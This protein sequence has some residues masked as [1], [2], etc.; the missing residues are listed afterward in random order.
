MRSPAPAVLAA[1]LVLGLQV[2]PGPA[3]DE[4]LGRAAAFGRVDSAPLVLVP[5]GTA[6]RSRPDPKSARLV[7]IEEEAELQI[8]D[9]RGDWV[10]TAYRDWTGWLAPLGEQETDVAIPPDLRA[11]GFIFDTR[12]SEQAARLSSALGLFSQANPDFTSVGPWPLHTDVHDVELL[13]LLDR[14]AKQVPTLYAERFGLTPAV[15]VDP[16]PIVL[17][18]AEDQYRAYADENTDLGQL[19]GGGHASSTMAAL[20][21]ADGA[22]AAD[23][24]SIL[25]HELT[26]LLNRSLFAE[27]PATWLEEGLANDLGITRLDANGNLQL[28]RLGGT[29]SVVGQPARRRRTIVN[30]TQT[31]GLAMRSLLI[32]TWRDQRSKIVPLDRLLELPW[33]DFVDDGQRR[34]NYALCAFFVRYLLDEVEEDA[35][36]AFRGFLAEAARGGATDGAALARALGTT[37]DALR[38]EFEQWLTFQA[39]VG[40]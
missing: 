2:A 3:Q 17:F 32:R 6:L 19:A 16:P 18:A 26:H 35:K 36:A 38:S 4:P 22:S 10:R 13:E 40:H 39:V 12:P 24:A 21:V 15:P 31:G 11:P 33:A 7:T 5:A 8:L 28:G 27:A 25:V 23:V 9:R 20:F 29:S 37:P 1:L 14:V 30:V 34:L